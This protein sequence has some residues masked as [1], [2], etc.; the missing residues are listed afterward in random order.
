MSNDATEA[1]NQRLADNQL[2]PIEKFVADAVTCLTW[3]GVDTS[4][5]E[6]HLADWRKSGYD[7]EDLS[8][9][10]RSILEFTR[11]TLAKRQFRS[12]GSRDQLV[13]TVADI[14]AHVTIDY[15]DHLEHVIEARDLVTW[16]DIYV[17]LVP[18]PATA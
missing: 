10:I 5:L 17:T 6:K 7:P 4:I 2:R 8:L 16:C 11:D 12:D 9:N 14:R 18:A 13:Q 1:I 15:V 3:R